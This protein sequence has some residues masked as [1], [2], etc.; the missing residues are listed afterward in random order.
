MIL[1]EKFHITFDE[2]ML[3][4]TSFPTQLEIWCNMLYQNAGINYSIPK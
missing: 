4:F 1:E 3:M 2:E